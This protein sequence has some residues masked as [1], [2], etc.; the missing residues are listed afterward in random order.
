MIEECKA[1]SRQLVI[2]EPRSRYDLGRGID[3]EILRG[4]QRWITG[5]LLQCKVANVTTVERQLQ[6]G[7]LV[8]TEGR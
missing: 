2:V 6:R 5:S 7:M 8:A 1:Q 4:T 3:L